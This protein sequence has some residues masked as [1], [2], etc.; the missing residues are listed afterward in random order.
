VS[1]STLHQRSV[2]SMLRSQ[3][4]L[5]DRFLVGLLGVSVL[6]ILAI[7]AVI[8]GNIVLHGIGQISWGFLSQPPKD[9]LTAGGI[10]PAIVGTAA[11][12]NTR[13]RKARSWRGGAIERRRRDEENICAGIFRRFSRPRHAVRSQISPVFLR[14]SLDSSGSDSS[15]NSSGG[16]WIGR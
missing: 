11:L 2:A 16:R 6:L 1:E 7:L 10:F 12:V 3:S 14:S 9:G 13:R 15:F 4:V 5:K 8:V